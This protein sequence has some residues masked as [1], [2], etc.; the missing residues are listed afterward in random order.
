MSHHLVFDGFHDVWLG[1]RN[2]AKH[3]LNRRFDHAASTRTACV[4]PGPLRVTNR[5]GP[6]PSWQLSNTER[7]GAWR[8]GRTWLRRQG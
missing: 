1:A 8:Q 7:L 4:F 2:I 6:Q 5:I 3:T